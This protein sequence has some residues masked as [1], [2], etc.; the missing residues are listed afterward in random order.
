MK[1]NVLALKVVLANGEIMTTARRA[2]K[3]SA[4]YD[5]TRLM[6]GSEG[7]LGVIT[8]LTLQAL[9]HSGS[10]LRRRLPVP[11]GR[12]GCHA[13]ILTIQSGIPVARIELL[14]ALQVRAVNL[15]SKLS[16]PETPMLFLEFHG[17]EA[18]VAEQSER[19]GEIAGEFG[20]GP[21][22]WT[23][24][25]RRIAPGCGRRAMTLRCRARRC[26][27]ARISSPPTSACRSR[28]WPNA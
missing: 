28:G 17:T 25:V 13:T 24:R 15:H 20:G 19:F 27:R 1:D 16:L 4:G 12:G 26:G 7:T 9:R 3:S 21:F 6:V 2:K 14:D 23:T 10:D 8:E 5:L 11:V 18:G 22:E